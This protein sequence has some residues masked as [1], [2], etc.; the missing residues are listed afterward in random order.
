MRAQTIWLKKRI[1]KEKMPAS[2]TSAT[3]DAAKIEADYQR[4]PQYDQKI[5]EHYRSKPKAQADY[6]AAKAA[7]EAKN[8]KLDA[9]TRLPKAY[10]ERK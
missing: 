1:E 10:G 3:T 9:D 4:S 8:A 2:A 7:V 6:E 5:K